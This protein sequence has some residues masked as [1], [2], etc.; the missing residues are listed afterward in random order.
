MA[1]GRAGPGV[2]R[3]CGQHPKCY[4]FQNDKIENTREQCI[5]T[6]R[7]FFERFLFLRIFRFKSHH[8]LLGQQFLQQ[9]GS[10]RSTEQRQGA[11]QHDGIGQEAHA[12]PQPQTIEEHPAQAQLVLLKG[13]AGFNPRADLLQESAW[14]PVCSV[15]ASPAVFHARWGRKQI[16]L[17]TESLANNKHR[18]ER[19]RSRQT[20]AGLGWP[21]NPATPKAGLVGRRF[22]SKP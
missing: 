16:A 8:G 12:P 2:C 5:N 22:G 13:L 14:P 17:D 6:V 11:Q 15:A 20:N 4:E 7:A 3:R 21:H 10:A 18:A 9:L 1:V 19:G